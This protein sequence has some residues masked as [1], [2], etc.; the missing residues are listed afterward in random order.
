[1][2]LTVFTHFV[3]IVQTIVDTVADPAA[4]DALSVLAP[5]LTLGTR[6]ILL[7]RLIDTIVIAVALEFIANTGWVSVAPELV[8]TAGNVTVL[9]VAVIGTVDFTVAPQYAPD[10][11]AIAAAELRLGTVAQLAV[12]LV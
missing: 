1:M 10:A 7:I 3:R 12:Q 6:A 2:L 5:I 9:L 11:V 8:G 4:E